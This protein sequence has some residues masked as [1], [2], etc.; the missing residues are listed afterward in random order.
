M[1]LPSS[2]NC[3]NLLQEFVG[4]TEYHP[5]A[6]HTLEQIFFIPHS[7]SQT[8]LEFPSIIHFV[9]F[10]KNDNHFHWKKNGVA[11]VAADGGVFVLNTM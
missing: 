9:P 7:E 6:K 1:D 10:T 8:S 4:V 3:R 5:S 11:H 2:L